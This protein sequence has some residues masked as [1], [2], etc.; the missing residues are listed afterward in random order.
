MRP[1]VCPPRVESLFTPA[2][3]S[4]CN[5]APLAFKAKCS[6]YSFSQCQTLR[7]SGGGLF[8]VGMS[9]CSLHG[10]NFFI[11]S[12]VFSVDDCHLFPQRMLAIIPLIGGLT[13]V[14]VNRVCS[15]Y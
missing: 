7:L 13:G 1:C 14:V 8:Y 2:L 3:W 10:F 15:G 4:S 12:T 9:L 11:V 6:G 5:P